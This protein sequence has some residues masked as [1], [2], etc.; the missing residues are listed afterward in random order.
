MERTP[1]DIGEGILLDTVLEGRGPATI[2]FE[3]GLGTP[4]EEWEGVAPPCASRARTLRYDR[5]RAS[6]TGRLAA[7]TAADMAS[8]LERLLAAC[9]LDPPYILVS[10]S[11]G[12]VIARAFAHRHLAQ[13]AGMV[14]VDATHEIIDSAGLAVMPLMYSAMQFAARFERGRG[15]LRRQLCPASA[16][17]T[18]RARFEQ[19]LN[20]P[21]LWSQSLRTAR[22][23]AGGMRPSFAALRQESPTLPGVPISV[24]TAGGLNG[25]NAKS[26]RRVHEAWQAAVARSRDATYANFPKSGHLMPMDAPEAVVHAVVSVLERAHL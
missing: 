12:G 13:I 9:H 2:V 8:D 4:L 16:P 20:N 21:A 7:R 19:R 14:F 3:N 10:H 18:Y 17:D 22:D 15:W 25:P 11:Y 6:P 26:V 23:E 24:L 5:R 1:V